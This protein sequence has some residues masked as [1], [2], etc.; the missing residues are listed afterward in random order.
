MD[1]LIIRGGARLEGEI[2]IHGAK[3]S[4]LPLLAASLLPR[5]ASEIRHCP[6]LSDVDASAAILRHL[7]CRVTRAGDTVT[8]DAAQ[9]TAASVPDALM[10]EMRSSIVFLGA[11]LARC[12]EADLTYPGGCELGPRPIDL[13]LAALGRLGV[14]IREEHGHIRCR[15]EH[16]LHG[17]EIALAFPSVGATENILLAACTAKGTTT[18]RHAAREPEIR[19]LCGYLNA[20][21]AHIVWDKDDELLIEGVPRLHG[22]TYTVMPDRIE[23]ATYLAAAAV[24]GSTLTLRDCCPVHISPVFPALEEAGC[25]LRD[26]GDGLQITAP[27]RLRKL[28]TVRTMPYPG[29]PTD[30][31]APMMAAACTAEGTSVFVE[32]IFENRYKVTDELTRMGARI[33]VDGRVAV[34]EGVPRLQGAPVKCTDLRGGAALV[35][36]ALAANGESK[37]TG[38][39]HLDRGYAD[40]D[41][42]LRAA[43]AQ[44]ERLDDEKISDSE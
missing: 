29:F 39:H 15:A 42:C 37:I 24:T 27:P 36:A 1:T 21:G 19:D 23:A 40:L 18:L 13:H 32:S 3:N 6:P 10:R 11:I 28:G 35:V 31:G 34:V 2:P 25:I 41:G 44:I 16:G 30:A 38:L 43:G 17:A 20:C 33:R 22:C 12:G 9:L 7:G 8:V 26:M 4:A 14:D 5:G